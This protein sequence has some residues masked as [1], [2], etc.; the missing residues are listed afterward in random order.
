MRSWKDILDSVNHR[1]SF[2][3]W[4]RSFSEQTSERHISFYSLCLYL[5]QIGC[6]MMKTTMDWETHIQES[7]EAH[8]WQKKENKYFE[9]QSLRSI[10]NI[11]QLKFQVSKC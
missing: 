2:E 11:V 7:M 3:I 8:L 4:Q 10:L 5:C 6:D 1:P 9:R